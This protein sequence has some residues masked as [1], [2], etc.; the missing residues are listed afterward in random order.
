MCIERGRSATSNSHGFTLVELIVFIVIVGVAL[1][2]VL[3]VLSITT[4]SSADPIQPKQ[5]TLVAEAMMEEI[6][7]KDYC[8]PDTFVRTA[9][10]SPCGAHTTEATRDLYDDVLDYNGYSST[11]ARSLDNLGTPVVGLE[12]YNVAV[13]VSAETTIQG[14]AGRPV[15]VTVSV[16][17]NSYALSSYRFNYD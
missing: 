5:A 13:V 14:A 17:G 4:K 1:A 10:P 9:S 16:G 6:L 7:A 2:G 3:S 15:T 12:N 11:G 8:D